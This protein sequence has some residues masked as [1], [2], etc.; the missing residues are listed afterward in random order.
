MVNLKALAVEVA[1]MTAPP[2]R[3]PDPLPNP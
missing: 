1:A 3:D 2:I